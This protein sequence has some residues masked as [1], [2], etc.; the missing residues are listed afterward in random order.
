MK[1]W[2]NGRCGTRLLTLPTISLENLSSLKF[3]AFRCCC[4]TL[5]WVLLSSFFTLDKSFFPLST[6]FTHSHTYTH[7]QSASVS[8]CLSISSPLSLWRPLY[9]SAHLFDFQ[10]KKIAS[11]HKLWFADAW[12]CVKHNCEA[13]RFPRGCSPGLNNPGIIRHVYASSSSPSSAP[14]YRSHLSLHQILLHLMSQINDHFKQNNRC[15]GRA[16]HLI[17]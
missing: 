16:Y 10:T 14:S 12:S 7:K 9:F 17:Q 11:L 13:H 15:F 2:Q 3:N 6:S 4:S 1:S 8:V 5:P